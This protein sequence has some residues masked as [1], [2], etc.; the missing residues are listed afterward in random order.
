MTEWAARR[1]W[2]AEE[3]VR[4]GQGWSVRLDGRPLRTPSKRPLVVPTEA[5]AAALADEW[6]A[7]SEVIDPASMPVTRA[8]NAAIEKVAV[9]RNAVVDALCPYGETDLL[10]YRAEAP[11]ALSFRQSEA[12][13]PILEWAHR[14]LGAR[15]VCVAG[16]MPHPQDAASLARLRARVAALDAFVLTGLH[17]LVTLSS[18]LIIGLAVERGRL[19]GAEAWRLSRIDEEY[20]A[21][22]WGRDDE[23]ERA[24]AIRRHAFLA[25]ER[26]ITMSRDR[27]PEG[28]GCITQS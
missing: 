18:S 13:D 22:Q 10:C 6:A 9:H 20:Q 3:V 15:L 27:P 25:A 17:D 21:E 1:F 2:T 14:D 4:E 5:M 11:D 12:W 23:A 19:H 16:V 24:A 28:H 26:F 7:Q 8:A